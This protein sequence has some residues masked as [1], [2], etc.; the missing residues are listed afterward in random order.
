VPVVGAARDVDAVVLVRDFDP[1]ASLSRLT[2]IGSLAA[3]H[4]GALAEGILNALAAL[5]AAGLVHGAIHPGNV[6]IG[7]DGRVTL[8]DAGLAP[9]QYPSTQRRADLEATTLLL[10]DV[11]SPSRRA[12]NRALADLLEQHGLSAAG[13]AEGALEALLAAWPESERAS[14]REGLGDFARRIG[15]DS[16]RMPQQVPPAAVSTT[17]LSSPPIPEMPNEAVLPVPAVA[18][19]TQ[20]QATR[21]GARG[22]GAVVV[23]AALLVLVV[24]MVVTHHAA[25]GPKHGAAPPARQQSAR[26]SPQPV[27]SPGGH[28][29]PGFAGLQPPA[30]AESGYIEGASLTI[31]PQGCGSGQACTLMSRINLGQHATGTLAWEV[32]SV[33]RCSGAETV[34]ATASEVDEP[35]YQYMWQDISATLPAGPLALYAVTMSPVRVASPAVDVPAGAADCPASST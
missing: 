3:R 32:V 29:Q 13:D 2:S 16:A 8:S 6:F 7:S 34:L 5:S 17:R 24:V 12:T 1:G 25:A 21:V 4:V 27:T 31:A 15:G 20:G 9:Q 35:A 11:W 30:A 22:I 10:S 19:L 28:V 18:A 33:G 14:G 26:A 23:V